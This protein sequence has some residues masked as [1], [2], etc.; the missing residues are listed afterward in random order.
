MIV[1]AVRR[2][3]YDEG[4]EVVCRGVSYDTF[5]ELLED[6][7]ALK[8]RPRFSVKNPAPPSITAD[9]IQMVRIIVESHAGKALA[10]YAGKKGIDVLYEIAKARLAKAPKEDH[11]Q[12]I[13]IYGPNDKRV[14]RKR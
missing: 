9:A 4:I 8:P 10:M 12:A 5:N 6:L 11:P 3:R 7:R 14:T 2:H 1:T 13:M